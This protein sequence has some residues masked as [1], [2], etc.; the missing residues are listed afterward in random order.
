MEKNGVFTEG[1]IFRKL[2]WFA[3]PVL[4]ALLLQALYGAAD[5][6]VVGRFATSADVS[7]V[8]TGSQF[9]Q[10]LT[11]LITSFSMGTTVLL[12]RQIGEGNE[13][14]SGET[15]GT[16]I[17]LF[18]G[19]A[20][21]L[22]LLFGI[23]AGP[24]S[25]M[26]NAP[27]EAYRATTSY[28][29]ICGLGSIVI[30]AYNLIG[31][32]F[33]G[34]GDSRTPLITVA[35]AAVIN[36]AGDLL[37]VG[38]F[39]MGAKGAA[40]A[41]VFSQLICVIISLL[42]SR[43]KDLPFQFKREDLHFQGRTAKQITVLGLPIAIQDFMVSLSFLIILAIVNSRGVT[44]SAGVG[45]AEKVCAFIM[46]VPISIMDSMS[47]FVAQNFGAKKPERAKKALYD[48]ILLSL[49]IGI[50]MGYV[51]FYHGDILA[52][53]FTSVPTVVDAAA[54]YL[55]AYAIDCI[56]VSFLFS[57]VGFYNGLGMTSFV[58]VQGIVGAIG[59]RV[60]VAFLMSRLEP[61]SLF[62]IGLASPASTA[63]QI[64][65]CFGALIYVN[66][67]NRKGSN[68]ASLQ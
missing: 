29:R 30:V 66:R 61:V 43:K 36:I 8:S 56:L 44:A 62:H 31:A 4:L 45:V 47:A 6:W 13:K 35:I 9:M 42:I 34:I 16:S 18:S 40:Y 52:G 53:I 60:P 27:A 7:A 2:V 68:V 32:V 50:F 46:L 48:S 5:L 55:K 10:T 49:F 25:K 14:K 19:L 22:M 57:F 54:S 51:A 33:R 20:L 12:G 21:L 63:V 3:F 37:L 59:I 28:L 11:S 64:L 67:K 39:H 38:K 15:I 58:M 24:I 26:M 41:T 1:P 17:I 65:L 23:L